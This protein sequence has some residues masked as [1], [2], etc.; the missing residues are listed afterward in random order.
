MEKKAYIKSP[1]RLVTGGPEFLQQVCKGLRDN[2]IDAYMYYETDNPNPQPA[3]YTARYGNPWTTSI[4]GEPAAALVPE[5][6]VGSLF[7][8]QFANSQKFILWESVNFYLT[9]ISEHHLNIFPKDAIHLYPYEY[10][11]RYLDFAHVPESNRMKLTDYISEEFLNQKDNYNVNIPKEHLVTYYQAKGNIF[12]DLVMEQLREKYRF[13]T[14]ALQGYTTQE[15][16]DIYT[17]SSVFVDFSYFPGKNRMFREALT[18]NN[19]IFTSD[20]GAA[21]YQEDVNIKQK[22]KIS[23]VYDNP[24]KVADRIFE[25]ASDFSALSE[26][27]YPVKQEV[28]KE[29][30]VFDE[31]IKK[32]AQRIKDYDLQ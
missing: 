28:F 14:L 16:I 1:P 13:T 24:E 26:D 12:T 10:V 29:K 27:F 15:L 31:H 20:L 5:I 8:P 22:Y 19:I 21:Y 3:P 18:C 11:K 7:D 17:R 25:A 4:P 2:G 30:E 32:L 23:P 6:E 9:C